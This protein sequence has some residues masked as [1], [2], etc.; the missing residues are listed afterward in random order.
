MHTLIK[1]KMFAT[2]ESTWKSC[3]SY[4]LS[5]KPGDWLLSSH[6]KICVIVSF[7]PGDDHS[8]D[9]VHLT[10][11]YPQPAVLECTAAHFDHFWLLRHLFAQRVAF[12]AGLSEFMDC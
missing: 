4:K 6:R 8:V 2:R 12:T 7:P 9:L 10:L 1:G 3:E 5:R 11:Q